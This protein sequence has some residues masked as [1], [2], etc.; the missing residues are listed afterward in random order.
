M[1]GTDIAYGATRAN[2]LAH[3]FLLR[4]IAS[5][6][7]IKHARNQTRKPAVPVQTGLKTWCI[8]LD[9]AVAPTLLRARY[10]VTG[11]GTDP[12][13]VLR[14]RSVVS[15]TDVGHTAIILVGGTPSTPAQIFV[16]PFTLK[17]T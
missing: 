15:G 16:N 7:K 11:Q 1:C 5:G 8:V 14:N 9:F 17:G 10:A 12:P 13:I 4:D 2:I 3:L 6:T